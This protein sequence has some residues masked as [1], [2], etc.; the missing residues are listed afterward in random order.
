VFRA[1]ASFEARYHLKG[2][3]FWI[4]FAIMFLLTFGAVTSEAVTIGGSLGNVNRNAPFV[5]MQFM[6]VMSLFGVLT[7]TAFVANSVHRD[8]ELNTD[9]L[10]F[11]SPIRK[12]EYLAGR[13]TGSFAVATLVY[14]GVVTAIMIG[15]FM[16]WLEKERIGPFVL[17][18][19]VYSFFVLVVPNLFLVGAIFF[20]VAALTRSMMATYSGVV[21]FFVA[22]GISR[23]FVGNLKNEKVATLLDPFGF[24]PFVL[25]TRYWTVFERNHNVLPVEG[26]FL[27][28]RVLWLAIGLIVLAVTFWKFD[29]TASLKARRKKKTADDEAPLPRIMLE[30]PHVGQRFG[31]SAS[32]HQYLHATRVETRTVLRSVPFLIIL[33]LGVLNTIGNAVGADRLFDTPVYPVTHLMLQTIDGGFLLFTILILAFYAGDIVFRERSLRLNEVHDAMPAP[34]WTIWAAKLTALVVITTFTLLIAAL[35]T[36]GYQTFKGYHHYELGLYAKGLLGD[37]GVWLLLVAAFAFFVQVVTNNKYVGFLVVALYIVSVNVLP[38]M[39]LEHHLYRIL[40]T[41]DAPYSDMNG[42]GHY[43]RRLATVDIYWAFFCAALIVLAHL[44]WPRGTDSALPQRLRIARQRFGKPALAAIATSFMLFALTGCYIFY[45]TNVLN[46]YVTADQREKQRADF[47]K[48]YKR[49][50]RLPQPR[51]TAVQADVDIFPATRAVEIRGRYT[52]VNRTN[53]PIPELHVV[54]NPELTSWHVDIPGARLKMSDRDNGY[55]IYTLAHPLAPAATLPVT[56]TSSWRANGFPN[57][58]DNTNVVENG[59]FINNIQY[60]PH[61]GYQSF[62]ELDDR[63]KRKKYGLPPVQ[64]LPKINDR[65]AWGNNEISSESDWLNLD[66]TVST[67][68]DQIAIA[69]GYLQKEWTAGGRRYFHYK[70]TSPILGFWSYLSARYEVKRDRWHDVNIEIYYDKDHPYNVDR[71][72]YAAKKSLDYFTTNFSPYQHRQVRI[73][74]F[75]R[76]ARFAQSFPNTIPFSESIGFIADLRKK[77]DIDY[78]YYVTA[79]EI[80]HQWWGHQVCG[81]AV[82]G[83]T[84]I[85]ETLAQYSALMVQEKEYGRDQMRKF[86]RHELNRYLSGRGGELVAEMPLMLVENQAYI[87]YGKGS[88]AMYALRD[89]IGEENVNRAL[90]EFIARHAFKGAPYARTDELV[91]LFRSVTP[92][93][94]QQVIT[95]LFESITLYD[96]RTTEATVKPL[97]GGKYRVTFTV[98]AK[99]LRSTGGGAEQA[100]ELNDWIDVG[101]LGGKK[102]EK[103]LFS[104]KRHVTSPVMTIDVVVNQKPSRAGIDPFHKLIDRNPDDNTKQL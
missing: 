4:L 26:V 72:I 78:V 89:Q 98:S 94:K 56:F 3:L 14:L 64:R 8:F 7:T 36:I 77:D 12:W 88:L 16:P 61:I 28:N 68:P 23:A 39:H 25:S 71:M 50:E 100:V 97:P 41:A 92:P 42:F 84:M 76:Y 31:G 15:S 9:S 69:P 37:A 60:F 13:F 11:S 81:A 55:S 19:Y 83:K 63:N 45:N 104:E 32:L 53:A 21:G 74:E 24:S 93:D 18:P 103:I 102:D 75:P 87:H 85:T 70:T 52:L 1:I 48:K 30:L 96:N 2:A 101:V 66:T 43:V 67:S 80:A 49:Y 40:A 65:A 29:F 91:S 34:T 58:N 54:A 10:F 20:C 5:I 59:T 99:K 35:T 95:D 90:R 73:L 62:G 46:R 86:L 6:L 79:H 38:A 22:Y 82:Q 57:G 47:E 17:Q 44:F 51:I 27:W 33:F